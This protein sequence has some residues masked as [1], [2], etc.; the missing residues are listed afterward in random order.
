MP[1]ITEKARLDIQF[2]RQLSSMQEKVWDNNLSEIF[3][4]S[5]CNS[6]PSLIFSRIARI[7]IVL[8]HKKKDKKAGD[9]FLSFSACSKERRSSVLAYLLLSS[10]L[11]LLL[12]TPE[13]VS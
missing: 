4:T 12:Y 11:R 5:Y 13:K 3:S 2:L 1:G 8:G 9:I 10:R 7:K 6:L